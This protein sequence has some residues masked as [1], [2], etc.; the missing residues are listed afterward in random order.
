MTDSPKWVQYR[1]ELFDELVGAAIGTDEIKASLKQAHGIDEQDLYERCRDHRKQMWDE[2]GEAAYD[3]DDAAYRHN[4]VEK[5]PV[6]VQ[7]LHDVLT[8]TVKQYSAALAGLLVVM[9]AWLVHDPGPVRVYPNHLLLVTAIVLVGLA[10]AT[11]LPAFEAKF[12]RSERRRRA[13][14]VYLVP[15]LSGTAIVVFC[16]AVTSVVSRD[17]VERA[18]TTGQTAEALLILAAMCLIALP[19]VRTARETREAAPTSQPSPVAIA[20]TENETNPVR[21]LLAVIVSVTAGIAVLGGGRYALM[22][23]TPNPVLLNIGLGLIALVA[24]TAL[25]GLPFR[26][27]RLTERAYEQA[28]ERVSELLTDKAILPLLRTEINRHTQIY[29]IEINVREAPGLWQPSDRV[30]V[31]PTTAAARVAKLLDAMSGGSIGLAGARGAGKT[32]LIESHCATPH[33]APSTLATMVSAPVE[34]SPREFLLHLYAK[35]CRAAIGPRADGLDVVAAVRRG[36]G[37]LKLLAFGLL[38]VLCGIALVVLYN[39][40]VRIP[41]Q[42][43]WALV[44]VVAGV[45]LIGRTAGARARRLPGRAL[46]DVAAERLEE[47]RFQQSFSSTWSGAVK[48]PL[49]LEATVGGGRGLTRQPLHL[50]EIVDSL[51]E[52]LELAAR[53]HRVLI[54]ID[55]LDKMESEVAAEQFLNEI[56]SIFGVRGCYFLVSVSEEAMSSFERRGLPFRDVFD[57]TFDEIVLF[58]HL[59]MDEAIASV[60]RRVVLMPLPFKQLCYALSG[61]LPRDLIRVARLALD[62][63]D[64]V[65]RTGLS[66][67]TTR[68]VAQDVVRKARAISVAARRLDLE[69]D[70]GRFLLVCAGVR[71][72]RVDADSL[73]RLVDELLPAAGSRA[74]LESTTAAAGALL[75]LAGELACFLYYA[76]TVLDFFDETAEQARWRDTSALHL[77]AQA[78]QAFSTSTRVAWEG[79]SSFRCSWQMA[80]VEF[81]SALEPVSASQPGVEVVGLETE[82]RHLA[83]P[84]AVGGGVG[85]DGSVRADRPHQVREPGGER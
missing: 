16:L 63:Q 75:K 46:R 10:M 15:A 40:D 68:L 17:V 73:M 65:G 18:G 83:R 30:Y 22:Y 37:R 51:R 5:L 85:V 32:T 80:P 3:Y 11:Q 82:A 9:A 27:A 56:K 66:R 62:A 79:I 36:R 8:S 64:G 59:T 44:L 34:Y 81:P 74:H 70:V 54:G 53:E 26:P 52:F 33:P 29:D 24:L 45:V 48:V 23:G 31:V 60:D 2:V 77:L 6:A 71:D 19:F 25:L 58:E 55:E 76:A 42:V 39:A 47:I 69:P 41:G 13:V 67:I 43:A 21:S 50:P 38:A 7:E 12:V 35:I 14:D 49:G 1:Q 4:R 20:M 57:S 72:R 84:R 61:G 78:R 28:R